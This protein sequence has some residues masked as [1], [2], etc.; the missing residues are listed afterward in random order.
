MDGSRD[1][2]PEVGRYRVL[3]TA[4]EVD[5]SDEAGQP[6]VLRDSGT[7]ASKPM[8]MKAA[9]VVRSSPLRDSF[10]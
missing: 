1:R 5:G 8:S 10:R 4:V 3:T 2:R 9:E 6:G 7:T